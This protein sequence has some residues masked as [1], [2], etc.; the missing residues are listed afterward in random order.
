MI[1]PVVAYGDPVLKKKAITIDENFSSL[2]D[3]IANMYETMYAAYGVG[4][5]APQVGY[6]VR[7]FLVD[8]A[9]FAEDESLSD[10]ERESL[11]GFKKTF[12]NPVLTKESGASWTFNEGCLSIPGVREDVLRKSKITISTKMKTSILIRL[13]MKV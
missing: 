7:L 4:L 2:K 1:L 12:I 9:P 11:K 6:S 8:T 13:P 5:A 3:L 10:S